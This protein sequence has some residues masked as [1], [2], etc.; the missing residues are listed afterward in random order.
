MQ[1]RSRVSRPYGMPLYFSTVNFY[2]RMNRCKSG[3]R[4][5]LQRTC[6][7]IVASHSAF[8]LSW[9]TRQ[10][11]KQTEIPRSIIRFFPLKFAFLNLPFFKNNVKYPLIIKVKSLELIVTLAYTFRLSYNSKTVNKR[12]VNAS[13]SHIT[14]AVEA[15]TIIRCE[16]YILTN[17]TIFKADDF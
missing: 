1:C 2:W 6:L 8:R 12:E 7:W 5:K 13:K 15:A 9:K 4:P 14:D 16:N 11:R 3:N 10:N 17:L